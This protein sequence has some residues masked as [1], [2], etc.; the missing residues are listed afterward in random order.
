MVEGHGCPKQQRQGQGGNATEG[1]APKWGSPEGKDLQRP[2]EVEPIMV[3]AL[4]GQKMAFK[5]LGE[6]GTE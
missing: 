5:N 3:E 6:L 1:K 4:Q 2:M